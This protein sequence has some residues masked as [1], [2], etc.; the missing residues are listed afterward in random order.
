MRQLWMCALCLIAVAV[1][2]LPLHAQAPSPSS[3]TTTV[4]APA[5]DADFLAE[6]Q[7]SQT[8]Q[9]PPADLP[10]HWATS[11]T[12]VECRALCVC[13]GGCDSVCL[14][15]NPCHCTCRSTHVPPLPC[16]V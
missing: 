11:C 4:S 6:L 12:P 3:P 14:S 15:T 8:P 7:T 5:A 9:A 2:G 1:V 16:Q 10:W 13:G